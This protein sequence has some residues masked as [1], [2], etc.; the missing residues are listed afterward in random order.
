MKNLLTALSNMHAEFGVN[1][2]DD[3]KGARS[4]Y[5]KLTGLLEQLDHR[6]RKHGLILVQP[7]VEINGVMA[8][9]SIL[10]H[11]ES[12]ES[13]ESISLLTPNQSGANGS[14]DQCYG[15]SST[16][17]R[18]YAAMSIC[19]MFCHGDATDNDGETESHPVSSD[20]SSPSGPTTTTISTAQAKWLY[21]TL[22]RA[23]RDDDIKK[24]NEQYGRFESLTPEQFRT[25]K[26]IYGLE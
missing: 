16:Y 10:T 11:L 21:G 1:L 8:I 5:V 22:K 26:K 24:I 7:E 9:K 20:K 12:K 23:N 18:R 25:I 3:A 4:N 2:I 14:T 6:L 17:H 15:G 19:G 13:L